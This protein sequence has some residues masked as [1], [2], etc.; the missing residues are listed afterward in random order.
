MVT[1]QAA[2]NQQAGSCIAIL[3]AVLYVY[4][5]MLTQATHAASNGSHQM[6]SSLLRRNDFPSNTDTNF[7]YLMHLPSRFPSLSCCLPSLLPVT[8]FG[9]FNLVGRPKPYGVLQ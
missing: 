4:A 9:P 5:A 1:H 7:P 2:M 8:A 3:I 6:T